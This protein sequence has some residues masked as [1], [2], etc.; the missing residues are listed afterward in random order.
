MNVCM[1]VYLYAK[2]NKNMKD[3]KEKSADVDGEKPEKLR[4]KNGEGPDVEGGESAYDEG[5]K[6]AEPEGGKA[7]LRV[8]NGNAEM[9]RVQSQQLFR[10]KISADVES[11][12]WRMLLC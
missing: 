9:L 5:E 6:S 3:K 7:A 11:E 2:V 12:E 8:K 10:R 1:N 4:V